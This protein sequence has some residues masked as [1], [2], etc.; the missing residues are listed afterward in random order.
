MFIPFVGFV[1]AS[2]VSAKVI[3]I[4]VGGD[5]G[6]LTFTPEAIVSRPYRDLRFGVTDYRSLGRRSR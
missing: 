6:A 3:D 5:G 2:T 4:Q 1:L